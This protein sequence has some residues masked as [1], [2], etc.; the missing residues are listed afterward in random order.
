MTPWKVFLYLS[1]V[2]LSLGGLVLLFPK[3][4]IELFGF[5]IR[6]PTLEEIFL[7]TKPKYADID[8]IVSESRNKQSESTQQTAEEDEVVS[9]LYSDE[10][11][12][13]LDKFFLEFDKAKQGIASLRIVHY[14][15]SQIE[16]DRVSGTIRNELRKELGGYG[17]GM[18][19]IYTQSVPNGVSYTYSSNWE[20]YSVLKPRKG[21]N[22]YGMPL[23]GIKAIEDSLSGSAYLEISFHQRPQCD[24]KIYYS[25]PDKDNRILVSDVKM[26]IMDMPVAAGNELKHLIIPKEQITDVLK[27]ECEPGLELYGLDI[28]AN[29]GINVDNIPLR[30]SSGWGIRGSNSYLLSTFF[31]E[32]GVDMIIMQFGVNAIPQSE[33]ELV[34]DY[35]FYKKEFAKQLQYLRKVAPD[36][37]IVVIGVSDRSIRSGKNYVTNPNIFK[38][39]E[40]QQEAA[41]ENGCLFWDLF[42]AMGGENSMPSWVLREIPLANKDFIHFN[43]KGAEL[44]GK[45]FL[46][47][48]LKEAE[49]YKETNN[50]DK[51]HSN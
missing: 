8:N 18:I 21:F 31:N 38:L 4:G 14:G 13:S 26:Q 10:A 44:V 47:A 28:S 2:L 19:P 49:A 37:V 40:A 5:E 11:K 50:T 22:H 7:D 3:E 9:F 15:D 16:G 6:M 32:F 48:L 12:Q 51:I 36:A 25:S 23:S 33:D 34:E 1:V 29:V 27:L 30:G 45:M 17:Q 39:R 35:G 46:E 42:M 20:F 43:K 41:L 24:L